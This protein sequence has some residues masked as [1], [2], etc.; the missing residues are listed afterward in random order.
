MS[1]YH[2]D[3]CG[4]AFAP[5]RYT[6]LRPKYCSAKCKQRAYRFRKEQQ[7]LAELM[8]FQMDEQWSYNRIEKL[9]GNIDNT[10]REFVELTLSFIPREAWA[11][12]LMDLN[13][14][15]MNVAKLHMEAARVAFQEEV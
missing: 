4:R 6:G 2:C 5:K 11:A 15:V 7:R 3:V 14:L 10:T 1:L 12:W 9:A 13:S 8:K